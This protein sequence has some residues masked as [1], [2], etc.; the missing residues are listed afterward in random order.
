MKKLVLSLALTVSVG[1]FGFAQNKNVQEETTKRVITIKDSEGEKTVVKK[2]NVLKEQD[3]KFRNAESNELNKQQA[4]T[5]IRVERNVEVTVD[6]VKRYIDVDRSGRYEN[7]GK[8]YY[9]TLDKKGYTVRNST[10][11][12][13][14]NLREMADGRY[15]HADKNKVS[16][17]EFDHAGN[18]VVETYD[19]K[20]DTFTKY[21]Y[22][23]VQ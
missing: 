15:V 20:D 8:L 17:L 10:G 14:A 6:G 9:I 2:E 1:I 19:Y 7:M 21:F 4:V 12:T 16:N 13:V 18:I 3:I 22:K 5:P 23:K 11:K